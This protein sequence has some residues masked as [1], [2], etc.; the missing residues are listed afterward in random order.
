M[1]DSVDANAL[2]ESNAAHVASLIAALTFNRW[3]LSDSYSA[4]T[5]KNN[6]E[7][8]AENA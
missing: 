7:Y 8:H 4:D 5:K 6:S 1:L 3:Y 2:Y